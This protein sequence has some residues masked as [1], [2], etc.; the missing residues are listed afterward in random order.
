MSYQ[1]KPM[2]KKFIA[3]CT[4]LV[5]IVSARQSYFADEIE[6]H[7]DRCCQSDIQRNLFTAL[8]FRFLRYYF[9]KQLK[10]RKTHLR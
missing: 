10:K 6:R 2:G 1:V 7:E 5:V 3:I 4:L 9:T 8:L